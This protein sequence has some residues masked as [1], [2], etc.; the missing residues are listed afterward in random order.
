MPLTYT[1]T[2]GNAHP[3]AHSHT[4]TYRCTD[5]AACEALRTALDRKCNG[6][7]SLDVQEDEDGEG[8]PAVPSKQLKQTQD[9]G[10]VQELTHAS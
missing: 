6:V 5:P 9:A 3:R 2:H 10:E 4:H 7:V 8:P 1:H